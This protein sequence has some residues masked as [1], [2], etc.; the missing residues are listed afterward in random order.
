VEEIEVVTDELHL[1][2]GVVDGHRIGGVFLF[3]HDAPRLS[4]VVFDGRGDG[5]RFFGCRFDAW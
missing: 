3:P 2:E 1:E 4:F 5:R